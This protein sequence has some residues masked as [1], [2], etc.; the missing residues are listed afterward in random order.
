MSAK[1]G[2]LWV[3]L[4]VLCTRICTDYLVFLQASSKLLAFLQSLLTSV[5]ATLNPYTFKHIMVLL[6]R[7]DFI[8]NGSMAFFGGCHSALCTHL[9]WLRSVNMFHLLRR[10]WSSLQKSWLSMKM[11]PCNRKPWNF[12]TRSILCRDHGETWLKFLK[13]SWLLTTL[14][15][16]EKALVWLCVWW[17]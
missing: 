16:W 17:I 3:S 8:E 2:I 9:Y 14:K 1:E 6:C 12:F 7:P 13:R 4:K 10:H 5:P 11:T 15:P